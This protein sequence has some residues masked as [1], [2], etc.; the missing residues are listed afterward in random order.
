MCTES[1]LM[2]SNSPT[3]APPN[4]VFFRNANG[5]R[6]I[7]EEKASLNLSSAD[8]IINFSLRGEKYFNVNLCLALF[9]ATLIV[10]FVLSRTLIALVISVC[11]LTLGCKS[12]ITS[13]K[14]GNFL[15]FFFYKMASTNLFYKK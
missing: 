2:S 9:C 10:W 14:Q 11:V 13:A 1:S 3:R 15:F 5:E 7:L 8:N 12:F 6:L 4:E